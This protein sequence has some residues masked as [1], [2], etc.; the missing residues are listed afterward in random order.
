MNALWFCSKLCHFSRIWRYPALSRRLVYRSP[1]VH[2]NHI[3]LLWCRKQSP[4]DINQVL[5]ALGTVSYSLE[6]CFFT[7]V[8]RY[9]QQWNRNIKRYKCSTQGLSESLLLEK[10]HYVEVHQV[11]VHPPRLLGLE[12]CNLETTLT[13]IYNLKYH[14]KK[15]KKKRKKKPKQRESF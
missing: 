13:Y 1:E 9:K 3:S 7:E 14:K 11:Q 12:N 4:W 8:G 10:T 15:K 6:L 2:S 5:L